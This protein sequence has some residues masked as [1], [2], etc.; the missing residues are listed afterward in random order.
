MSGRG[1]LGILSRGNNMYK[2]I[3]LGEHS[4]QSRE[5]QE[6]PCCYSNTGQVV[7]GG[8]NGKVAGTKTYLPHFEDLVLF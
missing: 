5:G 7:K 2:D 8:E 3:A 1:S 4:I 6:I